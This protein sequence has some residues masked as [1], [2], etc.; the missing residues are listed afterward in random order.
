MLVCSSWIGVSSV[1][2]VE[3]YNGMEV[4]LMVVTVTDLRTVS[5]DLVLC[6]DHFGDN[7]EH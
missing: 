2:M 7:A 5:L 4:A 1:N 3:Y 6:C